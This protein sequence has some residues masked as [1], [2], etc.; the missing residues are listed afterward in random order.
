MS[1][2]ISTLLIYALNRMCFS[3]LKYRG[4]GIDHVTLQSSASLFVM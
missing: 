3:V 2:A 4:A 1:Y